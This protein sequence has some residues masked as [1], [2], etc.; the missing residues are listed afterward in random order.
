[1][2]SK[3]NYDRIEAVCL[4]PKDFEKMR[5]FYEDVF[6]FQPKRIQKDGI[7]PTVENPNF[8]EY[9]F[10]SATF[11]LWARDAVAP[12]MGEENLGEPV[13]PHNFMIAL[14][15]KDYHDVDVIHE[16]FMERGVKCL[17]VPT[18]HHFG[19]RA[20]YYQDPEGT[21]WEIYGWLDGKEGPSLV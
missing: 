18:S 10:H 1:M 3:R 13:Q 2:S 14:R 5:R 7:D 6:G 20:A 11:A 12:I 21:I 19:S 4:F 17:S 9:E 16:G 15:V 8:I